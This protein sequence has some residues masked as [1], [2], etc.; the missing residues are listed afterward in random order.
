MWRRAN[1]HSRDFNVQDP[2]GGGAGLG[3]SSRLWP[4]IMELRGSRK[5]RKMED[6]G[7]ASLLAAGTII[8]SVTANTWIRKRTWKTSAGGKRR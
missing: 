4:G 2:A 1:P 6:K 7:T 8:K 3:G 5:I